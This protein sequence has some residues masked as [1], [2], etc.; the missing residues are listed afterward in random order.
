MVLTVHSRVT[1]VV[2]VGA[3]V[4]VFVISVSVA[5]AIVQTLQILLTIKFDSRDATCL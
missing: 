2:V 3:L 1:R 4:I 5:V